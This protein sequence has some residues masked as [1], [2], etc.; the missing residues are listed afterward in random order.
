MLILVSSFFRDERA[1]RRHELQSFEVSFE[2]V[3]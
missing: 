2:G 3:S 1:G